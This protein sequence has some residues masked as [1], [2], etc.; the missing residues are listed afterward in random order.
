M[1]AQARD[2]VEARAAGS[3]KS[4]AGEMIDLKSPNYPGNLNRPAQAQPVDSLS[5]QPIMFR[6]EGV[7]IINPDVR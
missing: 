7:E 1:F 5:G 2:L 3:C 4:M 6:Y